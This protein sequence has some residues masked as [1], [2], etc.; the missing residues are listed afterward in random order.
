MY[1]PSASACRRMVSR[2]ASRGLPTLASTLYSRIMRSTM[3]SRCSSPVPLM[4]VWPES[5][6]VC[7]LKVGS[8]CA[9]LASAMLIFSWSALVFGSTATEIMRGKF[10]EP[11]SVSLDRTHSQPLLCVSLS[12]AAWM[13]DHDADS[14]K[15]ISQAFLDG[16]PAGGLT[17]DRIVD[18]MTLYWLTNSSTSSARLYWENFR[19]I[20]ASI[21]S[22]E[23]SPDLSLPV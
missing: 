4:M 16:R 21:A 9:S 13:L 5:G 15:K 12:M 23:K 2:Y 10:I 14:Y 6:S 18:N 8:S 22:G 1:L 17:R 19:T 7:T 3:I 11:P 20:F